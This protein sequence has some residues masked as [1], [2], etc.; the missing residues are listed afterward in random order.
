MYKHQDFSASIFLPFHLHFAKMMSKI[1]KEKLCRNN[2]LK[3]LHS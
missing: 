1:S 3:N 2:F